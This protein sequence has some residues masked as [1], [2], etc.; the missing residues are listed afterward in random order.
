MNKQLKTELDTALRDVGNAAVPL[1]EDRVREVIAGLWMLQRRIGEWGQHQP[2]SLHGSEGGTS[3]AW[4]PCRLSSGVRR[5]WRKSSKSACLA[6]LIAS[7]GII[8][9]M[10]P[11]IGAVRQMRSVTLGRSRRGP[12]PCGEPG[13]SADQSARGFAAC[14]CSR[15]ARRRQRP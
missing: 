15:R 5:P 1:A 4:P 8:L 2:T 14:A 6:P 12:H 9:S 3:F 13:S 7:A 11:L 10:N